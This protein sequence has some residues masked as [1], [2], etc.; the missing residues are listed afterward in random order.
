MPESAERATNEYYLRTGHAEVH[1][2]RLYYE[3]LGTGRALVLVHGGWLDCRMW[4]DQF[5]A[6]AEAGWCVVR[7]D[8]RGF[9]RSDL[10]PVSYADHEDLYGLLRALE[11]DRAVVPGL[12]LGGRVALDFALSHPEMASALVL[13]A[14]DM[15][16]YQPSE[17]ISR[18]LAPLEE[19]YQAAMQS[20]DGQ[21]KL[22]MFLDLWVDGPISPATAAIRE[23]ARQIAADFS[24][25][26]LTEY[27]P[28]RIALT[29]PAAGRLAEV[30]APTLVIGSDRDQPTINEIA[31][32]LAAGIPGALRT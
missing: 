30:H 28:E 19:A 1:G 17:V 20:G 10:P 25:A 26:R 4:D 11:I 18:K 24:F 32:I 6:F 21:R 23:R 15:S 8:V 27:A 12:S 7:Y 5:R 31:S 2:A 16:G 22:A 14:S 13:A 9:G 3:M 29:P